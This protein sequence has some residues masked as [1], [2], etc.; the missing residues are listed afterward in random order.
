MNKKTLYFILIAYICA[1]VFAIYLH[2]LFAT[3]ALVLSCLLVA[4]LMSCINDACGI[5]ER[6]KEAIHDL[7]EDTRKQNLMICRMRAAILEANALFKKEIEKY[8]KRSK[9]G[10]TSSL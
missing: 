9:Q 10:D 4:I 6:Q 8:E 2:N 3:I 7:S 5:I 1:I